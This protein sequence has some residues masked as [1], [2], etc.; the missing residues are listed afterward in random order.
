MGLNGEIGS[1]CGE[2]PHRIAISAH[3]VMGNDYDVAHAFADAL[4]VGPS[5]Y[6]IRRDDVDYVVFCFADPIDADLFG[7]W[8]DG[9]RVSA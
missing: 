5:A 4:S 8:F 1:G 9:E 3:K 2:W 6:H 7:A